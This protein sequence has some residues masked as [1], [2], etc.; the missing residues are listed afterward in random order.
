MTKERWAMGGAVLAA[1]AASLCCVGP[2]LF[3]ALGLEAFGAASLFESMRPWLLG[4]TAV[5]LAVG[6]Y[7]TYFKREQACAPG[8]ACGAKPI[9]R[10]G[11]VGLWLTTL[12][13]AAFALSPYYIGSLTARLRTRA[14]A[15]GAATTGGQNSQ[16]AAS[17]EAA[18][19]TF[20]VE[21][22]TCTG[23]ETTLRLALERA[24]GVRRAAV[25]YKNGEAV[26][27]YDPKLTAPDKLRAAIDETGYTIKAVR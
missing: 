24:V 21:G 11:R 3:V 12:L 5:F 6:F 14:A 2:L 9:N 8:E 26:V 20:A 23:C 27:D 22:L 10:A 25:S 7:R 19:V 15:P 17:S 13:V 1:F 18:R 16:A 4:V